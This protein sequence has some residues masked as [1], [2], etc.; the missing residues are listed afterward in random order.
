MRDKNTQ[1]N[2]ATKH[3]YNFRST[4][5]FSKYL[6]KSIRPIDLAFWMEKMCIFYL[7]MGVLSNELHFVECH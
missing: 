1:K 5:T 4:V 2:C 7:K 3:A 6:L